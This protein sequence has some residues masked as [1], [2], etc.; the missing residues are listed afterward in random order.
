[1]KGEEKKMSE[2]WMSGA[3]EEVGVR[4]VL[5]YFQGRMEKCHDQIDFDIRLCC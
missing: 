4:V 3:V 5:V 2:V 1:M